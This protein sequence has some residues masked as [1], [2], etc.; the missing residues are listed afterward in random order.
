MTKPDI[1]EPKPTRKVRK[2]TGVGNRGKGRVQGVPNKATKNAREAIARLVDDN[3]DRIQGWLNEIE[4]EQGAK[5]ALA[6]FIDLIEYH[7]PKLA[8]TEHTGKDGGP[9]VVQCS[10]EDEKL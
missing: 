5:A 6:C 3:A 4:A 7:V 8:R 2:P 9:L 10:P 1:K